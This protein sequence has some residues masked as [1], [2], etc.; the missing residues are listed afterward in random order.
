MSI[1]FVTMNALDTSV[2][3]AGPGETI[4]EDTVPEGKIAVVVGSN[5]D[6]VAVIGTPQQLRSLV[7]TGMTSP[8]PPGVPLVDDEGYGPDMIGVVVAQPAPTETTEG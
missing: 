4:G 5:D 8:V 1:R 6:A 7:F 2:T 3:L